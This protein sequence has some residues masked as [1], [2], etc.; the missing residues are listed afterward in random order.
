MSPADAT[1]ETPDPSGAPDVLLRETCRLVSGRVPLWPYHR[2]RLA[3]GGCGEDVLR[4]VDALVE[5]EATG[6]SGPRS[7]RLR[8]TVVATPD[9]RADV[10]V[11]R[12]LSSLDVPGGPVA[13]P[14]EVEGP[15][16]LPAGAAKPADRSWWDAAQLRAR[17][18]SADQAVVVH[19]GR[20]LDGGT[21]TVWVVADGVLFT[22]P[23]PDAVAGVARAFVLDGCGRAGLSVCV[24][25]VDARML[26]DADELFLTNAFAGAV[27]V[28]GRGG[29]VCDAVGAEFTRVWQ[30]ESAPSVV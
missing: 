2:R 5:R 30:R 14:V 24:G 25:R 8:L 17:S 16:P 28:R 19:D 21:A 26:D 11:Q 4:T 22:P 20:V 7:S 15:P 6:W 27:A 18:L 23:A 3:S 12:R 10:R 1:G 29:P 9:G 13:A